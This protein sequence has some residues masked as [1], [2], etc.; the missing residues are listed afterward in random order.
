MFIIII[1]LYKLV[2]NKTKTKNWDII[3]T[4]YYICLYMNIIIPAIQLLGIQLKIIF[5]FYII[6]VKNSIKD[7][8]YFLNFKLL[9][10]YLCFIIV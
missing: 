8:I 6:I 7:F 10:L 4:L 9:L 2:G 1:L 3:K 5:E